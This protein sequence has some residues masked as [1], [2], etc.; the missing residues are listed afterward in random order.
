MYAEQKQNYATGT[1]IGGGNLAAEARDKTEFEME[2]DRV[3]QAQNFN[4]RL[5]AE[6][7]ERL[8]IVMKGQP[9]Q[10]TGKESPESVPSSP[11]GSTVRELAYQAERTNANLQDIMHSL[12]V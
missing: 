10:A 6:L 5:V 7:R 8:S 4:Q 2:M 12:A 11:I 1:A 9:P 3:R